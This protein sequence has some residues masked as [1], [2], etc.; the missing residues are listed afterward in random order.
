[1]DQQEAPRRGPFG[2]RIGEAVTVAEYYVVQPL[3][4][5]PGIWKR[6]CGKCGG[7]GEVFAK[8]V[9]NGVCF[10][11]A[12][13]GVEGKS[14]ASLEEAEKHC[15]ALARAAAK[16]EEKRRA[17]WEAQRVE[18]EAYEAEQRRQ[19]AEEAMKRAEALAAFQW[20]PEEVGEKVNLSGVVK[21]IRYI[22][23]SYNR[24]STRLVVVEVG[25]GVEVKFFSGAQFVWDLE[26]GQ[27]ISFSAAVKSREE[28]NGK[29]STQVVRPKV[30]K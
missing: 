17:E 13:S 8:W 11:C 29:R 1:M 9:Y 2:A 19:A 22:E 24:S 27:E 16:R 15:Q 18:R 28:F 23:G 25:P 7:L 21:M 6:Q 14:F 4:S 10:R 20:L 30:S 12:G 26:E 3:P 5:N